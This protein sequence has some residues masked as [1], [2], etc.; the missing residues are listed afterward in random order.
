MVY[1]RNYMYVVMYS[2]GNGIGNG[3][4]YNLET[5]GK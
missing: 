2:M 4:F 5:E 1:L 3:V